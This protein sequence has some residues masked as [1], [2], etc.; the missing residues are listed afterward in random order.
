LKKNLGQIFRET[1][2]TKNL[3][4]E[5]V[6]RDLKI[7]DIYIK[8]LEEENLAV[9]SSLPMLRGFIRNYA[10]YL[11]LNPDEILALYDTGRLRLRQPKGISFM[12]LPVARSRSL[13][14]PDS[15]VTFLLITAL[16]GSIFLFVY[17][18]YL[19]PVEAEILNGNI[20]SQR[21]PNEASTVLTLPTP[22]LSP[23]ETPTATPTVTPQ[24]YTG[25]AIELV[26]SERS[27]I[28]IIA[29]NQKVFDGTLEVGERHRWDGEKSVAIRA[30]NAG[31]VEIYVNGEYK[32][33]M[34]E[35]GQVI[36]QLWEKVETSS[37]DGPAAGEPTATPASNP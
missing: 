25:V 21:S 33:F 30:G 26:I 4:Y 32:G 14:N 34:G 22:T 13:V 29:D 1:R 15:V 31:G 16:L 11:Q 8:A 3:S 17:T 23:T 10:I 35:Q 24:Y 37:S 36:D 28:Q 19:E 27:W 12:A 2:E 9:F 7:K 5:D 6:T 20:E 18:Q